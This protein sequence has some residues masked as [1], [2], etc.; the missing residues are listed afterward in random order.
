MILGL[1]YFVRELESNIICI[2][3][4]TLVPH[5][6]DAILIATLI[7]RCGARELN[8]HAL[9]VNKSEFFADATAVT[10]LTQRALS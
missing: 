1:I 3:A 10:A 7:L 4:G 6:G 9:A 2:L 8:C 5:A